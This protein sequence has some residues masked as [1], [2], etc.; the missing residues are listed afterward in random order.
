MK[1][2]LIG[3]CLAMPVAA[4]AQDFSYDFVEGAYVSSSADDD[5]DSEGGAFAA[6]WSPM[7]NVYTR[8]GAAY[9]TVDDSSIDL[10]GASATVGGYSSLTDSVD[11]YLGASA[12]WQRASDIPFTRDLDGYGLGAE[13][14]LRAWLFPQL[15]IDAGVSYFDLFEGD[16]DDLG[17]DTNDF[18]AGLTARFYVTPV[19]SLNAGYSYAFDAESDTWSLGARYNF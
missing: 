10:L 1:K 11:F 7:E 5:F 13:L 3:I 17:A 15:E 12:I 18:A 6:G 2:V 8:F 4:M 16:Y 19:V 14:G 9:H